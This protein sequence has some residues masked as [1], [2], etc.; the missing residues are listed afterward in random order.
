MTKHGQRE[1]L[2]RRT[3][4]NRRTSDRSGTGSTERE[5]ETPAEAP[6]HEA[7]GQRHAKEAH[8]CPLGQTSPGDESL[9]DVHPGDASE[10][11]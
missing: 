11:A 3:P 8:A 10:E 1:L 5:R 9:D 4:A 7:C 6:Y 2:T